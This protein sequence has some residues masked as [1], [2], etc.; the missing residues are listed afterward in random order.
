MNNNIL[1]VMTLVFLTACGQT[2]TLYPANKKAEQ[3]GPLTLQYTAYGTGG[4]PAQVA[5]PNGEVL[6][7]E[8]RVME[9]SVFGFGSSSTTVSG[10]AESTG[11]A[12]VSGSG[13]VA[14]VNSVG[15]ASGTAHG[16]T[17]SVS[18]STP[19]SR[20]GM[21]AL[22]GDKG[23]NGSCD[24]FVNRFTGTGAGNCKFSNGAEYNLMF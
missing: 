6:K 14:T 21:C 2:G 24:F 10:N 19:G 4:G 8:Y 15:S 18:Q 7:G 5:M 20:N 9:N 3:T 22:V 13:G 11:H 12:T 16:T 1:I 17:N 23:T